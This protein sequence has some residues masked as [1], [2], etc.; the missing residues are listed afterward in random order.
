MQTHP[1]QCQACGASGQLPLVEGDSACPGCGEHLWTVR[2]APQDVSSRIVMPA[3]GV[4]ILSGRPPLR[5]Q[6]GRLGRFC[7][8]LLRPFVIVWMIF[9][10]RMLENRVNDKLNELGDYPS[11]ETVQSVLGGP[12]Y[13]VDGKASELPDP[14]D[15]IECYE[16]DGCC[17][18]LWFKDDRLIDITGFVKPSDW[19]LLLSGMR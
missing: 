9:R 16:S 14:P 17:V 7:V 13:A 8:L 6:A 18:D 11:R 1:Y 12:C 4:P 19:D 15:L 10:Q 3:G 2:P 5:P